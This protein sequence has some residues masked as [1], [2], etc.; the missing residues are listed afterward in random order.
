MTL[1]NQA[2]PEPRSYWHAT[3][4][5]P[6]P[7]DQLPDAADVVVVGGGMLGVWTAYWL[8][9][10]GAD[11]ALIERTAISWGATGRNGGFV[12]AG[13][14]DGFAA[15]A[16]RIGE[17]AAW[18][19]WR[20][21]Q[22]GR[23]I[24]RQVVADE[25]ID[26]DYRETGTVGL[27]LGEDEL[28]V[29]HASVNELA[30][31][32][33]AVEALDRAALQE[34]V[35]TPL[36]DEIAGG[37]YH[38]S[39]ALVHSARY[40]AGVA[41]AARRRGARLCHAEVRSLRPAGEGTDVVTD[42]GVV[43]TTRVVVGVNAWTDELV[44]TLA[45]LVVP[46]RGQ[47]LSYEPL[48]PVFTTG[49]GAAVTPTGEYW[50]QALDGSIVIGGCRDDAPNKDVG[51]REPVPTPD[52]ISRIADVLPRLFPQLAGLKVAR[53]WAGLMAFTA[54]YLPVAGPAPDMPGVWVAGGFCG[55][56]MPFGPSIG[57][58]LAEAA[59]SGRTPAALAPLRADRPSLA[60][61]ASAEA[62]PAR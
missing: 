1:E 53:R 39:N 3:A 46:V 34:L 31:R 28:D 45:G 49:M 40:L 56:G 48:P 32:G 27:I 20:L 36:G 4:P 16:A 13:L 23:D 2:A 10:A 19:V 21:S 38:R 15:T 62:A 12:S 5:P 24:V 52:V 33:V 54:D 17:Q 25:A 29:K 8:A 55:H 26:C 61:M 22:E 7:S 57:Q 35:R 14:A 43:R 42:R 6:V 50:Q 41:S 9:K 30:A 58:L 51:V 11:V 18:D 37:V 44:P 59:T 47:I 60:R